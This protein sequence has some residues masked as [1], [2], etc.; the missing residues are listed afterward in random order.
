MFMLDRIRLA[1]HSRWPIYLHSSLP[2]NSVRQHLVFVAG[3][4]TSL[5]QIRSNYS[6]CE[7]ATC[8]KAD[9]VAPPPPPNPLILVQWEYV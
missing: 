1:E 5:F 2:K 9:L 4:S 7:N 8:E 3:C 6:L